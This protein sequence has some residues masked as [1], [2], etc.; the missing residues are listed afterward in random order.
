MR[1]PRRTR[2]SLLLSTHAPAT[3][4]S[5][6]RS[7]R[8]LTVAALSGL[9]VVPLTLMATA[10]TGIVAGRRCNRRAVAISPPPS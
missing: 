10:G 8:R 5:V 2:P 6:S 4:A 9:A 7:A 3:P 1:L